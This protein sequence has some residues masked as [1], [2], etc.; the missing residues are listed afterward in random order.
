[1]TPEYAPRVLMRKFFLLA[2]AVWLFLPFKAK[3][4]FGVSPAFVIN[5]SAS[6]G[7]VFAET[8]VISRSNA[9]DSLSVSAQLPERLQ[10]WVEI[11]PGLSFVIPSGVARFPVQ[12]VFRVP[13]DADYGLYEDV[14][15]FAAA[16]SAEKKP[17]QVAVAL[18]AAVKLKINVTDKEYYDFKIISAGVLP[19]E[20][21]WPFVFAVKIKNLGNVF[22]R[23]SRIKLA[24]YDDARANPLWSKDYYNFERAEPFSEKEILV[25]EN[26]DLKKGKYWVEYEIYK[27]GELTLADKV[28]FEVFPAWTLRKKPFGLL[29][30][31]YFM[32][33]PLR[34]AAA[35]SGGTLLIV[36]LAILTVWLIR[37]RRRIGGK[38]PFNFTRR[39]KKLL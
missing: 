10:G 12:A 3:A 11:K 22:V 24:I 31:E 33:S 34:I 8:I 6:P 5:E 16:S 30:K 28:R 25:S 26:I 27:K 9:R 2:A 38:I 19:N 29:V 21:G 7:S 1:M 39:C 36:G 20:E 13:K 17:G 15:S 35:A 37:R 14:L 32:G 23:P 4:G 18:G